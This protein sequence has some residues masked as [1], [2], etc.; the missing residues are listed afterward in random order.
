MTAAA[1]K[2]SITL[3]QKLLDLTWERSMAVTPGRVMLCKGRHIV[4]YCS[5]TDLANASSIAARCNTLCISNA[6]FDDLKAWLR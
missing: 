2:L 4:G 5:V 1:A 3:R 6:D